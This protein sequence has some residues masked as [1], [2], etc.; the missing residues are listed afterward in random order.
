LFLFHDCTPAKTTP[1]TTADQLQKAWEKEHLLH[2]LTKDGISRKDIAFLLIYYLGDLAL[3]FEEN[4]ALYPSVATGESDTEGID[5]E[6]YIKK[7]MSIGWMRNFPDGRFYPDDPVRRAH[8][9]IILHRVSKSLPFFPNQ[10]LQDIEIADVSFDDYLYPA[11][12][13]AV[14]H[15]LIK[16]EESRFIRERAVSGYEAARALSTFRTM[17]RK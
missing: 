8:F 3:F 1:S 16:M 7:V 15:D 14:S 12:L 10:S 4:P 13:F 17:L 11:I 6:Q 5:E 9:A 2:I